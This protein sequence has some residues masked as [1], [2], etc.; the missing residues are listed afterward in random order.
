MES[1]CFKENCQNL[2]RFSC[3]CN[4]NILMC[5]EHIS[6]HLQ[7]PENH[8]IVSQNM[9]LKKVS[10]A[11]INLATFNKK[12]FIEGKG[13]LKELCG[14]LCNIVD[15]VSMR[16]QS[17]LDLNSSNC[18]EEVE[19]KIK[20]L[21]KINI[22]FRDRKEFKLLL[23]NFLSSTENVLTNSNLIDFKNEFQAIVSNLIKSNE[24][25]Q[26]M[27]HNHALNEILNEKFEKHS[28]MLEKCLGK[29]EGLEENI[30][31]LKIESENNFKKIESLTIELNRARNREITM[32]KV[33][34][35]KFDEFHNK[36]RVKSEEFKVQDELTKKVIEE[37]NGAIS[38][39]FSK[40]EKKI[41]RI[42]FHVDEQCSIMEKKIE[43]FEIFDT[44]PL[45]QYFEKKVE[46][47]KNE[48]E[49]KFDESKEEYQKDF[50]DFKRS[51]TI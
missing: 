43:S 25:L 39:E 10:N 51:N 21:E 41:K 36:I 24:V 4:K 1:E 31:T 49:L 35:E 50:T 26:N 11:I 28:S 46:E 45:L 22:C 18:S 14:K 40:L 32:E 3:C 17:L 34:K 33:Y 12:T 2:P 7:V 37:I 48:F 5:Q 20:E 6:D 30:A 8:E 27:A 42:N 38:L 9:E 23:D 44:K 16:Q 47:L 15:E 13:M 19:E 29:V